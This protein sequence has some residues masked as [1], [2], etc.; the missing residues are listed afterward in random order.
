M[1]GTEVGPAIT[2]DEGDGVSEQTESKR[3][4]NQESREGMD[5]EP[6]W[7]DDD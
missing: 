2:D 5:I 1:E 3:A 7:L 6:G 4:R